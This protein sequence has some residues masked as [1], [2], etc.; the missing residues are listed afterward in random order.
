M[1]GKS[2]SSNATS[3]A[4]TTTTT[5]GSATGTVGSVYQGQ[6]VNITDNLPDTAVDVFKELI[7][8]TGNAIDVA[9]GA[10]EA[11]LKSNAALTTTIKQPDVALAQGGQKNTQYAITAAAVV[12]SALLLRK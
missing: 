12:A 10:G 4:Q 2:S 8:L 3:S 7:H 9:A 1:G 5:S 11:A 6:T